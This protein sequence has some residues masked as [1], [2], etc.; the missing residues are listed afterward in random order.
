MMNTAF[1]FKPSRQAYT[2]TPPMSHT[3]HARPPHLYPLSLSTRR[4]FALRPSTFFSHRPR[5]RLRQPTA[6][7]SRDRH[8]HR[9]RDLGYRHGNL[10]TGVRS[11]T[12]PVRRHRRGDR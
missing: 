2:S 12:S 10:H 3:L 9:R 7:R 4:T 11:R 1:S 6:R 5:H 8:A